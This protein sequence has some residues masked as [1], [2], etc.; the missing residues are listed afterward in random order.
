VDCWREC[1]RI[2]NITDDISRDV[3]DESDAVTS[4]AYALSNDPEPHAT[5]QEL[6]GDCTRARSFSSFG[7]ALKAYLYREQLL[8]LKYCPELKLYSTPNETEGDFRARLK[9]L[10]HEERDRQIAKLRL[11][12]A[13][14]DASLQ[15]RIRKAEQRV[16]VEKQQASSATMS[17]A[18]TVG[19]SILG[20]LF[21]RKT[22]SATNASKMATSARA[23]TRAADQRGDISRAQQNVEK[24]LDDKQQLERELEEKVDAIQESLSPERLTLEDYEVKPRK[25]DISVD[26]VTLLWLPYLSGSHEPAFD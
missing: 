13:A 14:R 23:A 10:A 16:D 24:Y 15:E 5:Y 18:I 7:T 6:P 2:A 19:T 25:S 11:D 20:A 17:A 4:D 26:E 9:H 8:Q 12:Y 1:W 21:G 22:F 3:W